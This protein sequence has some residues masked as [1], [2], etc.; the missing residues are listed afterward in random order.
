MWISLRLKDIPFL[1]PSISSRTS[2]FKKS[3]AGLNQANVNAKL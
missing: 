3:Y 1:Q 2:H